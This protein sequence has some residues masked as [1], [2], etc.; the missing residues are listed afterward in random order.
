MRAGHFY[1]AAPTRSSHEMLHHL[2][3]LHQ[4]LSVETT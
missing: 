2:G 4:L 3:P 1:L